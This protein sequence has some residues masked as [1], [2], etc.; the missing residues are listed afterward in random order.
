MEKILLAVILS[1]FAV[2]SYAADEVKEAPKIKQVCRNTV[3]KDGKPVKKKD[4]TIVQN[5]RTVKIHKKYEGTAV[6]T[7]PP[8][9]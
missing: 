4:G 6:P 1:A 8:K 2:G 9:K 7:T 3:G 5:C